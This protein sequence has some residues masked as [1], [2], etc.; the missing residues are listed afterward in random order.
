M[1]ALA[2][3]RG[4]EALRA[5][6]ATSTEVEQLV[7]WL[8]TRCNGYAA[9][10]L[11]AAT[12]A[13]VENGGK[14][15]VPLAP[16][17][18]PPGAEAASVVPKHKVLLPAFV[19][20]SKAF[21]LT[22]H[23][24]TWGHT[25]WGRF[26]PW[27]RQLR[28]DLGA[29][30]WAGCLEE[31]LSSAGSFHLHA[32]LLWTDGVGVH[33][34]N[35]DKL[36]FEDVRPRVD[37]CTAT[38]KAMS[39]HYAALHGLWYVSVKKAGTLFSATNHEPGKQYEAQAA[40]VTGL[41]RQGKLGHAAYLEMSST[42]RENHFRQKRDVHEILR[43]DKAAAT[44]KHVKAGL[45]ALEAAGSRRPVKTYEL[46]E[47]FVDTFREDKHVWRRPILA[48]LGASHLGKSM[49][50]GAVLERVGQKLG[51][52]TFAGVTVEE[53]EHLDMSDFE[54][55]RD[56]G[57]LLDGL[58]DVAILT[59]HREAL[60][61]RPKAAKAARSATGMYA[62]PFTLHRRAVV[63]TVDLSARNL[64][65]F[66]THHWLSNRENVLVLRLAGPSFMSL[67]DSAAAGLVEGAQSQGLAS[68]SPPRLGA[69]LRSEHLHAAAEILERN[70]V[71]GED[72][73][74]MTEEDLTKGLRVL[75]WPA[76]KLLRLRESLL[77][78]A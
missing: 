49:L 53:D 65:L 33:L 4:R 21:M 57:I 71:T 72:F 59:K 64:H 23:S 55:D 56:A 32:Y 18:E 19:L 70:G 2:V 47:T 34:R 11:R 46:V 27:L 16:P 29:R 68:W 37:K 26:E 51:L 63:A 7:R 67:G 44:S 1:N 38:G 75:P 14:L 36:V 10:A 42:L 78:V 3:E 60:Q 17:E 24:S 76:A 54:V 50:A 22:Y 9:A 74:F 31:T 30:A 13:W 41:W 66:E 5:T 58:A 40:W 6:A 43:D 8:E 73:S 39:S 69:W 35:T 62:F 28:R 48:I 25:V 52:S 77:A 12:E 15:S 20:K 61:G 45:A